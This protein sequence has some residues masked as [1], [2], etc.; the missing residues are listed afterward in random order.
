MAVGSGATGPVRLGGGALHATARAAPWTALASGFLAAATA[1]LFLIGTGHGG[2]PVLAGL[3][4]YLVGAARVALRWPSRVLGAANAITLARLV[5]TSWSVAALAPARQ[6]RWAVAVQV[7][8]VVVGVCC[9]VLDGVDGRVARARGLASDFGARF[10]V[11][12]D[13]ALIL[14]LSL[15]VAMLD[16]AGWWVLGIGLIRYCYVAAAWRWPWL[17][18]AV[19]PSTAR[20]VVGVAQ[21]VALLVALLASLVPVVPD[22]VAGP[23]LAVALA[24]LCWSF[25][26]DVLWQHRRR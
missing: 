9:L 1:P 2:W 19:F 12:V 6:D 5:L 26:R 20:K 23:V 21:V 24:G 13:A 14:A 17:R 4:V 25:G 11:E 16:V 8:I 18:G 22:G 7:G 15:A 3:V 10:D